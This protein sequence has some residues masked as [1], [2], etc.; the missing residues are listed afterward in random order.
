[1]S[2]IFDNIN[3]L[4]C[5]KD[6]LFEK[7]N[8]KAQVS[9]D[10]LE[11]YAQKLYNIP[12]AS[13]TVTEWLNILIEEYNRKYSDFD[14]IQRSFYNKCLYKAIDYFY[15]LLATYEKMGAL[16]NMCSLVDDEDEANMEFHQKF[17]EHSVHNA[18][19]Y[20]SEIH[21]LK[22]VDDGSIDNGYNLLYLL[23][24]F[25]F[26]IQNYD[27]AI[28]YL[29]PCVAYRLKQINQ[30]NN[31]ES[32]Q[33]YIKSV[34]YLAESYEYRSD[35][36]NALKQLIGIDGKQLKNH[37]VKGKVRGEIS[38]FLLNN[39]PNITKDENSIQYIKKLYNFLRIS[40]DLD[41]PTYKIFLLKGVND[42]LKSFV[43]VVA[44]C[45]SE[46]ASGCMAEV[47]KMKEGYKEE[48]RIYS[49][50]QQIS[51]FLID[52][53]VVQDDSYVTCQATIRAENDACPEA[54]DILIKRL[55]QFKDIKD[56]ELSQNQKMEKAELQ[57]Y[58]FYFAEQEL[59]INNN[60]KKWV[61]IFELYGNEFF[62]FVKK[63]EDT[64][65]LFHYLVIRFK[66]LLKKSVGDILQRNESTDYTELDRIYY[67][68]NECHKKPLPHV[69]RELIQESN[70]LMEAYLLLREYRYLDKEEIDVCIAREFKYRL[71]L[72]KYNAIDNG[73]TLDGEAFNDEDIDDMED[74]ESDVEEYDSNIIRTLID[75]I[76]MRKRILILAPVKAAPSCSTDYTPISQLYKIV[77]RK[78]IS[79]SFESVHSKFQQ[80]A[81]EHSKKKG[82]DKVLQCDDIELVK[83]AIHYDIAIN[84]LFLYYNEYMDGN[85]GEIIRANLNK[86]EKNHLSNLLES[87][88]TYFLQKEEQVEC[89]IEEHKRIYGYKEACTTWL[90][91]GSDV[92]GNNK[93]IELLVFAE[94]DFYSSDNKYKI[95]KEDYIMFSVDQQYVTKYKIICFNKLP[96]TEEKGICNYCIFDE[97]ERIQ[98]VGDSSKVSNEQVIN[99]NYECVYDKRPVDLNK[100]KDNIR[101]RKEELLGKGYREKTKAV[102]KIENAYDEICECCDSGC[103]KESN[104]VDCI[105][106]ETCMKNG[107]DIPTQ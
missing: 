66:Y 79:D 54:I 45:L 46:F 85:K 38:R 58:I 74:E 56:E 34:I 12:N 101:K 22:I 47:A 76:E 44:H 23:G 14:V 35:L 39:Y 52:W 32:I 33:L 77:G 21:F 65:A 69:F 84:A 59:N 36:D 67:Q 13:Q 57:F 8:S 51:R 106:L 95:D 105:I 43:H 30:F 16:I 88:K 49:L 68:I 20:E 17:F 82:I 53:L 24:F 89:S 93:L 25:N 55:N 70:R 72:K 11:S 5:L 10:K 63:S 60:K 100:L 18:T 7:E 28:N 97:E 92:S 26:R 3:T 94:F 64:N 98:P 41:F 80:V 96:N 81:I 42:S 90:I 78:N 83:W 73:N 2:S 4:D 75:E 37:L 40:T 99:V 61:D 31:D 71:E 87:L 27:A 9:T 91:R 104:T 103:K 86:N 29:E 50:L 19:K 107:I 62:E 15:P 1:M 6:V 48:I 102:E